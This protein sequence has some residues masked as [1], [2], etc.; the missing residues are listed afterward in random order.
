[1]S[2]KENTNKEEQSFTR[3]EDVY[4]AVLQKAYDGG[5]QKTEY[6]DNFGGSIWSVETSK[7][8][9]PDYNLIFCHD[10]AKAFWGGDIV[11]STYGLSEKEFIQQRKD[12]MHYP[13]GFEIDRLDLRWGYHLK[14]MVLCDNPIDY[15]RKF[16]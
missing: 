12:G 3:N 2:T 5:L 7:L 14:E 16:I 15:L 4:R 1:M 8:I 6:R 13:L 9:H 11:D 10:F